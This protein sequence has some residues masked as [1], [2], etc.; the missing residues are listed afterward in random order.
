MLKKL[1]TSALLAGF[2]AGALVALLQIFIA[3]PV[4]LEAELYES[5]IEV[6]YAGVVQAV[7]PDHNDE[8]DAEARANE[9]A[10]NA[11]EPVQ[12]ETAPG[13]FDWS[14]NIQ[15]FLSTE[16]SYIGYGLLLI[17]GMAFAARSGTVIT[18]RSGIIWG[19]AGFVAFNLSPGM[20]LPPELPGAMAAPLELRQIWWIGTVLATIAGLVAIGFGKNWSH[21]GLGI[22][23]LALPHLIGAPLPDGYGGVVPPELAGEFVGMTLAISAIGWATLGLLGGHFWAKEAQ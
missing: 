18:A 3:V 17:A 12:A 21:W 22:V 6:H 14:R 5:G 15:T 16:L 13:G 23:L 10:R 9:A 4:I 7:E 20:G 1:L 2:G 11:G 19:V 8:H